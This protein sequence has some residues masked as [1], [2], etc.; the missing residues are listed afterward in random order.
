MFAGS[1]NWGCTRLVL[2]LY[3]TA[4]LR[5]PRFKIHAPC[6]ILL[7]APC[8]AGGKGSP[9]DLRC[10]F[11]LFRETSEMSRFLTRPGKHIPPF[12]LSEVPK[13]YAT[14]I[15]F[16]DIVDE[17]KFT[18][19]QYRII[20]RKRNKQNL[21]CFS[22]PL[23]LPSHFSKPI[24]LPLNSKGSQMAKQFKRRRNPHVYTSAQMLATLAEI[25]LVALLQHSSIWLAVDPHT[26][27]LLDMC[28]TGQMEGG[29]GTALEVAAHL[30]VQLPP[31]IPEPAPA[32]Q[33]G[34]IQGHQ[35]HE[36]LMS[37]TCTFL[38]IRM[39]CPRA[40]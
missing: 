26:A 12:P 24:P 3:Q 17:I 7:L 38:C 35:V 28:C 5:D 20:Y 22:S 18:D 6:A 16:E 9:T 39:E 32:P 30:G 27:W 21:A 37:S 29:P 25:E 33:A 15:E 4:G 40:G 13:Y 2:G 11:I 10:K 36:L 19:K 14:R 23:L 8:A 31:P 34:E 1:G